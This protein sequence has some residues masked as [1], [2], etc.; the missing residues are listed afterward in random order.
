MLGPPYHEGPCPWGGNGIP[1]SQ[2]LSQSEEDGPSDDI[3]LCVSQDYPLCVF[4]KQT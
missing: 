2:S 3:S 1:Q 4:V